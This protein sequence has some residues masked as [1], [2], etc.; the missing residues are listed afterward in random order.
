MIKVEDAANY[1]I[2]LY[3]RTDI[4]CE[5]RK[6]QKL[7]IF[8]DILYFLEHKNNSEGPYNLIERNCFSATIRG[9]SVGRLSNG[10]YLL[11]INSVNERR[12]IEYSE[13]RPESLIT[14]NEKYN[15]NKE[16][17][18]DPNCEYL[19]RTFLNIGAFS[20]DDLTIISR[21]TSLWKNA[22]ALNS[23]MPVPS[24]EDVPLTNEMYEEFLN[25]NH[26]NEADALFEYLKKLL[27]NE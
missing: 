24:D 10:I 20:G 17:T 4:Q 1:L 16:L 12:R 13:L 3:K 22:R 19:R 2:T 6:L 14:M 9:L 27:Q 7:V 11:I 21:K 8:A 5:S 23:R 25:E 26:I 15:Y 18:N